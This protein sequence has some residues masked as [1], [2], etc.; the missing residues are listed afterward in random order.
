M[1]RLLSSLV[2]G[3]TMIGVTGPCLA[4]AYPN[5]PIRM[6]VPFPPAG[7]AD[8]TARIVTKALS[9][10]LGQTIIIENRAG[11]D[12]AIAGLAVMNAPA[13]GYTLLFATTTGLNGAPTMR[14]IPPYD[15]NTA[16]T[17][18]SLVGRFG[19]FMF[20]NAQLPAQDMNAFIAYARA[21]PGK[22]NYGSGNGTS[23]LTTAQF[24]KE[25]NLEMEHVPYKGDA[26]A[27]S[28]LI[29]GRIQFLIA[30]PGNALPMVQEGRLR[31]LMALLPSRS[32]LV[33]EV[34]TAAELGF[35]GLTI[36]PWAG[37]FG[38]AKLPA[39]VVDRVAK[40]MKEVAGRQDVRDQLAK[41][42]FDMESSTPKALADFNRAQLD[43]WGKTADAI[44]LERN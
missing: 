44:N 29:A 40:A 24:A 30:T 27:T 12:G 36:E 41:I 1:K 35:K 13:D 21:N 9:E 33:P 39:N 23:I 8:Q 20:V 38:P 26:A 5:K 34:P 25:T 4:Q 32:P 28:D 42:A 10:S 18:I 31:V 19:F 37:L 6:I 14:K 17:P 11:A 3:L 43:I 2:L 15:P 16:F 22:L 7:A